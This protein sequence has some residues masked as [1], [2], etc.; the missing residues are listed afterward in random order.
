[1]AKLDNPALIKLAAKL[2]TIGTLAITN[3]HLVYLDIVDDYIHQLFPLLENKNNLIVK[4]DYFNKYLIGAHISVIYPE[5]NKLINPIELGKQHKFKIK[6]LI[7]MEI[8][9]KVY[10]ALRVESHSLLELRRKYKLPDKLNFRGIRVE[11][12]ITIGTLSHTS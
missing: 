1:M 5:E 2:P 9:S 8:N 6:N 12:H 7:T 3:Q 4:P 10:Y 11:F